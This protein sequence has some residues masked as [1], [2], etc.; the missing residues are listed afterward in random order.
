MASDTPSSTS[1]SIEELIE[2]FKNASARKRRALIQTLDQRTDELI[3]LGHS[4]MASFDREG[5]DWAPGLILQLIHKKD[6]DFIS[7]FSDSTQLGWLTK[8]S[9]VGI[10]YSKFSNYSLFTASNMLPRTIEICSSKIL[11]SP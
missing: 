2:A 7:N 9:D 3:H 6:K 1:E 5:D 10:D 4:V 11:K 8:S